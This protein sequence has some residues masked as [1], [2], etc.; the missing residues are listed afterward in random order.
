MAKRAAKRFFASVSSVHSLKKKSV[1]TSR[2]LGETC[3]HTR[4]HTHTYTHTHTHTHMQT[5]MI[6]GALTIHVFTCKQIHVHV[7]LGVY[8]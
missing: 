2:S 3:I 8:I 1:K 7:D 5:Y 4:I 6:L